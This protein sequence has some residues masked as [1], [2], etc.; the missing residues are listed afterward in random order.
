[1]GKS[2]ALVAHLVGP[3][4]VTNVKQD[5][6]IAKSFELG[7]NY[8]NPF[9]PTTSIRY[10]IP[11]AGIVTLKVYDVIGREVMEVLNQFQEVGS[12]TVNLDAS[13]L[14]TGMYVYP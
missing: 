14:A 13:K 12:Y 3:Y 9:N 4:W 2:L 8:P 11:K 10:S 6:I 5:G 7:Q 1:M